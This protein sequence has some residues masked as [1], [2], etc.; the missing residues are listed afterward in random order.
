M[1][2]MNSNLPQIKLRA[3]EPEDLDFFYNIE[4]NPE[5]WDISDFTT[6][7]SRYA[8]HHFIAH[9]TCNIYKDGQVRWVVE[10]EK[11][12]RVGLIDLSNFDPH[13]SSA[14]LG[15]VIARE[16]RGHK[17]ALAAMRQLIVYATDVLHL[18]QLYA[19]ILCDNEISIAMH[20]QAGFSTSGL[21]KG[22][23]RT[24]R[25]YSDAYIMQLVLNANMQ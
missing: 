1:Y 5:L 25:G 10:N 9:S 21:L 15:I 13:N 18:H 7:Y 2:S 11:G 3:L 17:Y 20:Q 4:N 24:S 6:P 16:H 22:W 14:E 8:L 23:F 12:D 19:L